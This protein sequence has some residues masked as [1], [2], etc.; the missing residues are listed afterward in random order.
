MPIYMNGNKEEPLNYRPVSLTSIVCKIW[1]KVIKKQ[2]TEYSNREGIVSDR[3]YGFRTGRSCVTNLS[4]YY[5]R[6]IDIIQ[7][8]DGWTNCIYLDLKRKAFDKV[9]HRKLL[10]KLEHIGGLKETFK[11]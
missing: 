6:V 3:Q 10:W 4:S 11:N 8:R 1:E 9:P 7:E 5:S 2:W